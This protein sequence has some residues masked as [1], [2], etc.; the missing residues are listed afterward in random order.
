MEGVRRDLG[1][2]GVSH[3]SRGEGAQAGRGVAVRGQA[4]LSPGRRGADRV[5]T[6]AA[7]GP[8]PLQLAAEGTLLVMLLGGR[9][10]LRLRL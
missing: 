7:A 4:V 10:L 1:R 8:R 3:G 9:R 6:A 5:R 2:A